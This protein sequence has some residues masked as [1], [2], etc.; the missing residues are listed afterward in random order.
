MIN[1]RVGMLALTCA[2]VG[3]V[4]A[5]CLL[6]LVIAII[7]TTGLPSVAVSV[8]IVILF[9]LTMFTLVRPFL[10]WAERRLPSQQLLIV[11]TVLLLLLSAYLTNAIG[12]HPVFGAFVMGLILPRNAT[13]VAQIHS[14]DQV[15]T[16]LFLPLFFVYSG[17]RTQVGL[18]SSPALWLL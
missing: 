8:V 10:A 5:W 16:I 18:I 11:L 6:A 15:N 4:L 3:D 2:A 7:H 9:T 1:T 17:L 13:F 12:I 14:V